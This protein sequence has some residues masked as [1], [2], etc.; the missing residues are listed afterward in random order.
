MFLTVTLNPALDKNLRVDRNRP[1][2]TLRATA[3]WDLAGGKGVNVGRGLLRVSAGTARVRAL[4]PLGGHAGAQV[5]DLARDEG[6]EV[7]AVPIAGRT[8]TAITVDDAET[9]QYWHY[10][11]PGPQ[12]SDAEFGNVRKAFIAALTGCAYAA[13]SGSL[14]SP[15]AGRLLPEMIRLARERGVRL[16]LDSSG[17]AVRPGLEAGPWLAKPNLEELREILGEPLETRTERWAALERLA[18]WGVGVTLLSN[19]P[20]EAL[21]LAGGRRFRIVPPCVTE[22]SDLGSGD[23]A[24][25]GILWAAAQGYN[26]E[27]CLAWGAAC[28]AAN[29]ETWDPCGFQR[30]RV[31]ELLTQVRVES[32]R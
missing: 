7:T 28:G 1:R 23:A 24:V 5:A 10:L 26:T 4:M 19:G 9:S 3:A 11:E 14:P 2:E 30:A 8:R 12:L 31:E 32:E 20:D 6:M 18:A 29:A 27:Q 13:V 17:G 22:I 16:A 15:E 25:A 21:A